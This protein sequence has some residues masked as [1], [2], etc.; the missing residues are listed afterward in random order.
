MHLWIA[1]L[2]TPG[3][4]TEINSSDGSWVQ[5]LSGGNYGFSKPEQM[6]FDG[7]HLWITNTDANSVTEISTSDGSWIRTISASAYHFDQ[8]GYITFDGSHIWI[9]SRNSVTAVQG[10]S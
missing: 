2:S 7:S 8:P 3:S 5:T 4:V 6:T 10:A 1:N 9:A